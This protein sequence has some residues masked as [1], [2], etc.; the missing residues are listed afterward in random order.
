MTISIQTNLLA[1]V[2]KWAYPDTDKP[3]LSMVLF[4]LGEYVACDG[5]RLVRVPLDYSGP[6]FGVDRSHLLAAVAA[7]REMSVAIKEIQIAAD[8]AKVVL[9]V[10]PPSVILTVPKRDAS[11]YPPYEQVMPQG[12]PDKLPERYGFNPRYLDAIHEV[13]QASRPGST[14]GVRIAAWGGS[15]DSMMFTNTDGIRFVVMP[16]RV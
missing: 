15:L 7:Q 13:D 12:K 2:A 9:T 11:A 6:S 5:H 3:H 14:N 1:A 16:V 10:A 4:T 8:D